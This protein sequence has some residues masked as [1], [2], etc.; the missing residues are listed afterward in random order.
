MKD[1]Y[2]EKSVL[3]D[4]YI[5]IIELLVA[6]MTALNKRV[7]YNL[8]KAYAN[9]FDIGEN[10]PLLNPEIALTIMDFILFKKTDD[11][12]NKFVFQQETKKFKCLEK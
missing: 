9:Q 11:F 4:A 2:L 7:A 12:I 6:R 1:T 8:A 5:V 3:F 10:Y